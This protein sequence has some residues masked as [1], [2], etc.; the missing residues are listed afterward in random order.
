M[1][2]FLVESGRFKRRINRNSAMRAAT[3]A[4]ALFHSENY[5]GMSL[6]IL[7]SV[8][9]EGQAKVHTTWIST[10][11]LMNKNGINFKLINCEIPK[12]IPLEN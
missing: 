11:E 9:K 3:D 1:P 8:L 2:F 6:G 7:T 4:F 12:L 5:N 10:V